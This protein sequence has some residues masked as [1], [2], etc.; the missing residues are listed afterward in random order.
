MVLSFH[1]AISY[2]RRPRKGGKMWG[3][4]GRL[5]WKDKIKMY[6]LWDQKQGLTMQLIAERYGVD[7]STVSKSIKMVILHQGS[8]AL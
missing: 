5:T 8:G 3:K 7:V 2:L 1:V 4:K 6:D